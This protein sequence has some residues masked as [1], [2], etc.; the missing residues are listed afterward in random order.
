MD[1]DSEED[2]LVDI[3]SNDD[4]YKPP[5]EPSSI[6]YMRACCAMGPSELHFSLVARHSLWGHLLWN[7]ARHLA[8]LFDTNPSVVRG[9]RLQPSPLF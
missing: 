7:G 3:F 8:D 6:S 2:V 4:F 9:K 1:S 5:S